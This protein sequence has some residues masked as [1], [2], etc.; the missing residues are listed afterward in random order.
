MVTDMKTFKILIAALG[1][2]FCAGCAKPEY[3][4]EVHKADFLHDD[5]IIHSIYC[6]PVNADQPTQVAGIIDNE[7]GTIVFEIPNNKYRKF[8]DVTNLKIKA[9]IAYDAVISPALSSKV[10][11]LSEPVEITVTAKMTGRSKKYSIEAYFV[12]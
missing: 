8:Y 1:M 2:L 4:D 7:E 11:D 12:K 9:N 5:C 10:W 3:G 6:Y